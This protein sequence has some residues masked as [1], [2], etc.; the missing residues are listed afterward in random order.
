MSGS[1]IARAIAAGQRAITQ[2]LG[3]L[4]D[5]GLRAPTLLPGWDRLTVMCHLR[6]GAEAVNR[7]VRAGLA[8]EPALYYPEGRTEQRPGTLHPHPGES[9]RG[10]VDSFT[11][12]SQ[13]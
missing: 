10:V 12:R 7:L 4:D 9:A 3:N 6:Y 8:G 13:E 1:V 11:E 2:A 5:A